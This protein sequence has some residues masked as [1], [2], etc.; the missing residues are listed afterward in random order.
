VRLNPSVDARERTEH[1][2]DGEI[3]TAHQ[4]QRNRRNDDAGGDTQ[5]RNAMTPGR[6]NMEELSGMLLHG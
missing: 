4:H 6:W 3:R 5:C 2:V 1:R